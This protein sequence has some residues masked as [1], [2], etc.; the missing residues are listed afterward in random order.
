M[1]QR[2]ATEYVK[3]CLEL[4]EAEMN[5]F[6][7]L[8]KDHGTL[9]QVKILDNGSQEVVFQDDAD[10]NIVLSFERKAGKY[11]CMGSCLLNGPRLTDVMRKAVSL[12][13]GDAVVKRIY[14]GFVMIYEYSR[15]TVVKIAQVRGEKQNIIYEYR[16]PAGELEK[17]YRRNV[18]EQEIVQIQEEID[19]FLDQRNAAT[20]RLS[21]QS[22]DLD[23]SKLSLRLFAL[24]G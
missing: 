16:D 19:T 17:L 8:F 14:N 2:L 3:T 24:E 12:F 21:R 7:R 5:Q 11:V 4:T 13:K 18:V 6:I 15:G 1:A 22:I 10:T 9:L 23:L 20:E